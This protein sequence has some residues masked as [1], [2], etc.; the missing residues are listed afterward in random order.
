VARTSGEPARAGML[1][2]LVIPRQPL[3]NWLSNNDF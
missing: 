3:V 1:A 2:V